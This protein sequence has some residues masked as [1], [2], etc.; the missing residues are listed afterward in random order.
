ML[1]HLRPVIGP[2]K[3]LLAWPFLRLGLGPF[4]V[5][6]LGIILALA[7]AGAARAGETQLS[8]WLAASSLLTDLADGEVARESGEESPEG[9]YLDAMGDRICECVLLFGLLPLAPNLVLLSLAGGCLVS[10]AKARCA[11]VC[12]MD[13]RDWPGWG[14]YPDRAVL[15]ALAYWFQPLPFWPLGVLVLLTWSCLFRRV[16]HARAKIRASTPEELQPY[17]RCSDQYQR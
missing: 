3:R 8:F 11:L 4:Q 10:F 16:H 7:A 1:S 15:I 13:N 6:V 5:G 9:N 17:L 14:D 2:L 12:L